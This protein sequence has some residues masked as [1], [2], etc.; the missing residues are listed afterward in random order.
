MGLNEALKPISNP[1]TLR[2]ST[3]AEFAERAGAALSELNYVHAFREGNGRTNEA[4]IREL[5]REH[6]H[7]VE[8]AVITKPRM[9]EASIETTNDPSS[10]AMVHLVEDATD[11]GRREAIRPTF[12]DLRAR[13]EDPMEHNIRTAAAGE[14]VTGAV[15]GSDDRTV[16]LVTD[17]GIVAADRAD[18]PSELP[19][20][21]SDVTFTARSDY[22]RP[23]Q[24]EAHHKTEFSSR[25]M[26]AQE[27]SSAGAG[28]AGRQDA[29][30][31]KPA[32]QAR[33]DDYER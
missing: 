26:E 16:S 7:E 4:F 32:Q 30:G 33:E 10:R 9:L 5:G 3:P 13:G 23:E 8:F 15:L 18:L 20:D 12:E 28:S 1:E 17:H 22:A 21:D 25:R 29:N 6:G 31:P 14:R 11:P 27:Q 2:G 24:Q 19:R